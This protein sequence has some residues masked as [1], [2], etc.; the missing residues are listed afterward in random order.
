MIVAE[1]MKAGWKKT[2]GDRRGNG[3]GLSSLFVSIVGCVYCSGKATEEVRSGVAA[4]AI[5][6]RSNYLTT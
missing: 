3:K 1:K 4:G 6:D 5:F 2:E